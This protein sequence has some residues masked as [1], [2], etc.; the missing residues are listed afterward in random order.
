MND[1]AEREIAPT[2]RLCNDRPSDHLDSGEK[3]QIVRSAV[4]KLYREEVSPRLDLA[5]RTLQQASE[6]FPQDVETYYAT[7]VLRGAGSLHL[8]GRGHAHAEIDV[9]SHAV[10]RQVLTVLR[11]EGVMCGV[12]PYTPE[13]LGQRP[14]DVVL[15]EPNAPAEPVEIGVAPAEPDQERLQLD[16]GDVLALADAAQRRHRAEALPVALELLRVD[17]A[18]LVDEVVTREVGLDHARRDRVHSDAERTRLPRERLG[19]HRDRGLRH[20]VAGEGRRRA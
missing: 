6:R 14:G 10:G 8:T 7:A 18:V 16:G 13:R 17:L 15:H 3:Q 1:D 12:R 19:E 5:L 4:M 11:E 9:G 20:R 2:P